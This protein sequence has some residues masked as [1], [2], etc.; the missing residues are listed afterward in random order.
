[1]NGFTAI[2]LPGAAKQVFGMANF[3]GRI[4]VATDVGV[5]ERL[6][7]DKW[8]EIKPITKEAVVA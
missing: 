5:F 3:K 8:A 4:L 1:M 7:D 6:P 2:P